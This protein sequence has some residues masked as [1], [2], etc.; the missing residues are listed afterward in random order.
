MRLLLLAILAV[1]IP[2][3]AKAAAPAAIEAGG[4]TLTLNGGGSR[5][6]YLM[7]M[8]HGGLYLKEPSRDAATVIAADAPMAIRLEITS[9]MVTQQRLVESLREGFHN[10]TGGNV[11]G[12]QREID[13]FQ[14][15]FAQPVA[16]GDVLAMV[17][18][19]GH[20]VTVSKNGQRVGVIQGLP[21]K[22][23]LFGIWLC[24]RPAQESLK[25]AML[26][27]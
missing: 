14:Q 13:Q 8:Y 25:V 23:A 11:A 12:I 5:T 18:L 4:V 20:G 17:Y 6:K 27:K 1:T 21:F 24:D 7:E 2:Q 10:A 19:P 22:Q 9:A 26:G 16:K 15:C 3:A